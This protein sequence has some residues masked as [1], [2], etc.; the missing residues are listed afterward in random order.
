V[1]KRKHVKTIEVPGLNPSITQAHI[2]CE[3]HMTC[4]GSF[5]T[6]HITYTKRMR[7]SVTMFQR[8]LN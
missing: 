2:S 7:S 1:V 4:K 8:L 3:N 6:S 5:R